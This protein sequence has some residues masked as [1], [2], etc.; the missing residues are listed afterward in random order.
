[1]ILTCYASIALK[2]NYCK[3]DICEEPF[4]LIEEGRHA[5]VEQIQSDTGF[6]P[7]TVNLKDGELHII[8]GPNMSGK[9]TLIR[10]VALIILMAQTGSWVPA[11]VCKFGIVDKIFTRVGAFDRL[12]FGQSTFMLEMLETSHIL[13]NATSESLIILD[14]VGRGTSTYDGLSLAWA[15]AEHI[16]SSIECKTLFATHYHQLSEL[17]ESYQRVK[18]FHLT[19]KERNGKLLLLYKLQEGATDHSFGISVAKMAGVPQSVILEA[20]KKLLHLE[21]I[22]NGIPKI[23]ASK[24]KKGQPRQLSLV[25]ALSK[26]I[27]HQNYITELKDLKLTILA[28]LRNYSG[29]DINFKTPIEALQQLGELVEAIK[30]LESKIQE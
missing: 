27:N 25:E 11:K 26:N 20:Q 23:R 5:V 19:A 24:H 8:T 6:I 15:I 3:P 22:S 30:D 4:I 18:N 9:S 2:N 14:E 1:D 28:F 12:A 13:H 21:S 17:D 16:V 7:N 29:I 10:Q